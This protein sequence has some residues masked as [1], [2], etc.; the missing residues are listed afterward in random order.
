[1][2]TYTPRIRAPLLLVRGSDTRV[3]LEV[4]SE[5][6][7]AEPAS[8]TLT[9]YDD[10]D[11]VVVSAQALSVDATT[12]RAYCTVPAASLPS[13]LEFSDAWRASWAVS[14]GGTSE[15]FHQDAQ[16]IRRPWRPSVTQ[17]D[18]IDA[19]P[20]LAN[21]YDPDDQDDCRAL[22]RLIR[23][24]VED[25]QAKMCSDG[26]R[27]WLV[28]DPWR[29]NRYAVLTALGRVFR[30][31]LFD[32]DSSN[33]AALDK[34]AQTYEEQAATEWA[35]MN[36]RYDD[37]QTGKGGDQSERQAPAVIRIGITR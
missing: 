9:V 13:T 6:G 23:A 3:E 17:Q 29:L 25:V 28:F 30:S 37:A 19:C 4:W 20:Q 15:V 7:L 14:V 11:A 12:K 34:L 36:F 16:L 18:L 2:A 24:A 22:A 32:Q 35:G 1:M 26:H 21:S 31:H 8:G 33:F 10:Q 5:S 27:P